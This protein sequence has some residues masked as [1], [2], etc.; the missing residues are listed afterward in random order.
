MLIKSSN[1]TLSLFGETSE[2]ILPSEAVKDVELMLNE[3]DGLGRVSV[4]CQDCPGKL[5]VRGHYVQITFHSFRGDI[6][7]LVSSDGSMTVREVLKGEGQRVVGR[8]AY[9]AV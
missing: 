2:I 6:L 4:E 8:S 1:F 3:V 5:L 7:P 9:S